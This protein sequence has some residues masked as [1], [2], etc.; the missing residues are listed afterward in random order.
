MIENKLVKIYKNNRLYKQ[1][2]NATYEWFTSFNIMDNYSFKNSIT[3]DQAKRIRK[4]LEQCP[5]RWAYKSN[6]A[7]EGK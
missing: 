4:V 3:V 2:A 5:S 1:D 6:W 7:F